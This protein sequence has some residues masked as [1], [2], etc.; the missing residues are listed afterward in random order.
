MTS[1]SNIAGRLKELFDA[2]S[3]LLAE[4]GGVV[5]ASTPGMRFPAHLQT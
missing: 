3:G 2:P 4:N 5:R 1:L